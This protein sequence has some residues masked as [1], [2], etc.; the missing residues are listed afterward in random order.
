MYPFIPYKDMTVWPIPGIL[1]DA[2]KHFQI[3]KDL[4]WREDDVLL[5]TYPKTGKF[6]VL[7]TIYRLLL[8]LRTFA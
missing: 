6:G 7:F 8:L 1:K 3:I 2:D 4:D 5:C